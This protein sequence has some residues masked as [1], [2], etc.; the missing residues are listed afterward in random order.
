MVVNENKQGVGIILTGLTGIRTIIAVFV[1][2]L[3][4]CFVST[5]SGGEASIGGFS[6]SPTA[7][8][9]VV[10]TSGAISVFAP[11]DTPGH[12]ETSGLF[13]SEQSEMFFCP[14]EKFGII[15]YT[16]VPN[17]PIRCQS[18]VYAIVCRFMG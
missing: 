18:S 17:D 5:L 1:V 10:T 15:K 11:A 14:M 16:F 12:W 4:V 13:V 6:E 8:K 2:F 7:F 9:V 3:I